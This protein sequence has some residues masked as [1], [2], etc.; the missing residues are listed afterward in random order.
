[1]TLCANG[2]G[3][4]V[5]TGIYAVPQ[6]FF[7]GDENVH[8]VKDGKVRLMDG[9]QKIELEDGKYIIRQLSPLECERLQ[10]L[11]DNYTEGVSKA[12]R[13]KC[14]GN[15]WTANVI[16][17]I[18]SHMDVDK[19][20]ELVVLSLFDGIATGRLVLDRLG[21]TN[22]KYYAYEIDKYAIEVA[23]KNYPDI[24]EMGDVFQILEDDWK[25]K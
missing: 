23:R 2:G 5:K 25:V 12:Q 21:F 13:Y 4:G 9:Y 6:N 14:I 17:F 19:D 7:E 18:L 22:V 20:E 3:H 24:I 10:T 1:M 15:G 11:P 8:E 16:E